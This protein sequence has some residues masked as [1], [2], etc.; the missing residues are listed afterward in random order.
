MALTTKIEWTNITWNPVTGCTEVSPGCDH[1]YAR[2]FAERFR[3]VAGHY[4]EHGFDVTLRPSKLEEP[5][6][7]K[8]PRRVFVNSM[9][10]LFHRDVSDLYID[11]IF[12]VMESQSH[13]T[14]QVLTKRP[15]R[16]KRYAIRRHHRRR[17]AP[18]IWLG[19]SVES[20]DYAWR[21]RMLAETPA[22]LRFLSVEPMI[23]PIDLVVL[24][25][26]GW[27]IAGGESGPGQRP[28]DV[29]WVR[30]LRDRCVAGGI[31]F[32]FKQW[33]KGTTGRELDGQL[34]EQFPC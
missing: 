1:C 27:V 5:K 33:H 26:V 20:N 30:E 29:K 34:W 3:G 2:R 17:I 12:D 11:Q 28:M 25:G 21:A 10:D 8:R 23:G 24:E 31:P 9:S 18:N 13:H 6:K 16:M 22:H 7:W 19:T 4:F 14:F 32:F 15:E